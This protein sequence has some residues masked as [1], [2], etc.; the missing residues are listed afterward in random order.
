MRSRGSRLSTPTSKAAASA[1]SLIILLTSALAF[2]TISSIFAGWMRPSIIRF[3]SATRAMARRSGS[4]EEK[5][6]EP[7]VSSIITSTPVARSNALMFRPSLPI[8]LPFRSSLGIVIALAMV[9]EA[10]ELPRRCIKVTKIS[11]ALRSMRSYPSRSSLAVRNIKSSLFSRSISEYSC[12]F[13][14]SLERPATLASSPAR[15]CN[16][17]SARSF[18]FLTSSIFPLTAWI[19]ESSSPCFLSSASSRLKTRSSRAAFFSSFSATV[20]SSAVKTSLALSCASSVIFLASSRA[21]S[22]MCLTS[23]SIEPL[24][25]LTSSHR[26]TKPIIAPPKADSASMANTIFN[27]IS[28]VHEIYIENGFTIPQLQAER[29]FPLFLRRNALVG[30]DIVDYSVLFSLVRHHKVVAVYVLFYLFQRLVGGL[31]EYL[32]EPLAGSDNMLGG[33]LDVGGL[34]LRPAPRLVD[35]H[36]G[37]GEREA[38]ALFSGGQNN[39]RGGSR[40]ADAHGRDIGLDVV[41]RVEYGKAGRDRTAGGV[42]IEL[43]VLFRVFGRQKEELG[44]NQVGGVVLN[45]SGKKYDPLF[46]QA[47]VYVEGAFAVRRL[48]DNHRHQLISKVIVVLFVL[49]GDSIVLTHRTFKRTVVSQGTSTTP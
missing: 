47:R 42:D 16:S 14:W 41:H 10:T 29:K 8:I 46:E 28:W 27:D 39:R 21:S 48:F 37:I 6:I 40:Y 17:T 23:T 36:L 12:S 31:G 43:N 49:H 45:R 26:N 44:D 38:L 30:E 3:S 9:S 19:S 5:T 2:S 22:S 15:S 33:Y 7:G 4:Y 13:A 34:S 32:I 25:A 11:L 1:F 24:R 35:H 20:V 18:M